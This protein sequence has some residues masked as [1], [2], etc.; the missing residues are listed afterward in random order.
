MQLEAGAGVAAPAQVAAV[1]QSRV[2][3]ISAYWFVVEVVSCLSATLLLVAADA[4]AS[5]WLSICSMMPC[6]VSRNATPWT[7]PWCCCAAAS[8]PKIS[9]CPVAAADSRY[10][11]SWRGLKK[12]FQASHVWFMIV[13]PSQVGIYRGKY[14]EFRNMYVAKAASMLLVIERIARSDLFQDSSMLMMNLLMQGSLY[15]I[16]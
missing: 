16:L 9:G 2:A 7:M 14:L 3:L 5:N 15:H 13:L 1:R 11:T 6:G 10:N 8:V 12:A 4:R